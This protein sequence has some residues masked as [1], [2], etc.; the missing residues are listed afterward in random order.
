MKKPTNIFGPEDGCD[1][2][3]QFSSEHSDLCELETTQEMLHGTIP[4]D[5]LLI[6]F[7]TGTTQLGHHFVSRN[8]TGACIFQSPP[9]SHAN[10]PDNLCTDQHS[11]IIPVWIV[12]FNFADVQVD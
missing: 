12:I 2:L 7:V 9:D 3:P 6:R 10:R 11:H 8:P 4:Y 1:L 5:C